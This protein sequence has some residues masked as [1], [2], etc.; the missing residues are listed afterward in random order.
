MVNQRVDHLGNPGLPPLQLQHSRYE[1]NHTASDAG[2][3]SDES[4][5]RAKY[6]RLRKKFV[7]NRSKNRKEKF[8]NE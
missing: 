7:G 5:D 4:S 6:R 3:I 8:K 2:S 1:Q